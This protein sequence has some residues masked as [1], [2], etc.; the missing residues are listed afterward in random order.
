VS[1]I[2]GNGFL[3]WFWLL[4]LAVGQPFLRFVLLAEHSGCSFSSDGTTNTRT[5]LTLW[6]VRWLMWNM[7]FHAEHHLYA[8][9]PFHALPSAHAHLAPHLRHI[10]PGYL[11]VHHQLLSNLPALAL[12]SSGPQPA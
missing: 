12:P 11:A 2:G 1:L 8:S 9:I 4:P 3:L 10:D 6:P 5:T 7:P